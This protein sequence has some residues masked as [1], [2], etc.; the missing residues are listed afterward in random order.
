[1]EHHPSAG[2][3]K[4][5]VDQHAATQ[6]AAVAHTSGRGS[7]VAQHWWVVTVWVVMVWVLTV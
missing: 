4:K 6:T 1:V 2:E 3:P 5:N 7:P